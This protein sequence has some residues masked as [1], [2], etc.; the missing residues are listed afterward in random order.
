MIE[1]KKNLDPELTF[2]RLR[3][4]MVSVMPGSFL[5]WRG[6]ASSHVGKKSHRVLARM[7]GIPEEISEMVNR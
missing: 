3:G 5:C 2:S 4:G 1:D 7:R 6:S